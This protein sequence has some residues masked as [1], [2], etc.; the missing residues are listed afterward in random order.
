MADRRVFADDQYEIGVIDVGQWVHAASAEHRLAAGVFVAAILCPGAEELARSD[1]AD[2][3]AERGS[4]QRVEGVRV[5]R[6]R[7]Y[8]AGAMLVE[9]AL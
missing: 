4:K 8:G 9:Y 5:A 2:E 6:I 7:A 1:L 3:A